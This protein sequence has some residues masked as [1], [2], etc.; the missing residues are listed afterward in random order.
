[1]FD[2]VCVCVCVFV[3]V[4]R[5]YACVVNMHIERKALNLFSQNKITQI[6]LF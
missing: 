3:C 6:T 2:C 1:M 5:V 4:Y